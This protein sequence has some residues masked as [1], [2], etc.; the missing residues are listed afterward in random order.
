MATSPESFHQVKNILRKLDQSIDAAR[1]RRLT[2]RPGAQPAPAVGA[3]GAEPPLNRAKPL[4]ARVDPNREFIPPRAVRATPMGP[5]RSSPAHG[6]ATPNGGSAFPPASPTPP[7]PP[8]P[9]FQPG[10]NGAPR[11]P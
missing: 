11:T 10:S 2:S 7:A 3:A 5:S 4:P 8:A 6:P 9:P 1:D